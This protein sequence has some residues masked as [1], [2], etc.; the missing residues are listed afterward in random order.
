MILP[1]TSMT[2]RKYLFGLFSI[3]FITTI[4]SEENRVLWDLGV[5]IKTS[6]QEISPNKSIKS[7]SNS[8]IESSSQ[9]KALITDPFIPPTITS[10][11]EKVYDTPILLE[12]LDEI[13]INS[14]YQVKLLVGRLTM[15]VNYQT[16][17][18]LI[19]Q[20]DFSH[21]N[22]NDR[23]DLNYWLANA[24]LHT[25][26]YTEAEDVI[27]ANMASTMDD[28]F[29]FLLAMIYESQGRIEKAQKEYLEFIKQFPKSDFK[30][31]ALIK[32]RMLGRR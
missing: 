29:Y 22:E 17:I 16:I 32:A 26:K 27:L 12:S 6:V 13:S 31:T 10:I 1:G 23:L 7:L 28:R 4:F 21:L 15:K 25:G 14:I 20:I 8:E 9:V 19:G 3:F 11:D 2:N 5:I 18:D 24:F 30:V